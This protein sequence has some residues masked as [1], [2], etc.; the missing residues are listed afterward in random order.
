MV[1]SSEKIGRGV[2]FKECFCKCACHVIDKTKCS[3]RPFRCL[4]QS[5]SGSSADSKEQAEANVILN[6]INVMC[7]QSFCEQK[8]NISSSERK[9]N[10]LEG[11]LL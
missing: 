7:E 3:E 9:E 8:I 2:F 4:V 11:N 6:Y 10:V 5:L 1:Q